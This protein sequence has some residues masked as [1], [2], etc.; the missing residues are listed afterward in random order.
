VNDTETQ[1]HLGARYDMGERN[2]VA[3]MIEAAAAHI[4]A[5]VHW[6]DPKKSTLRWHATLTLDG[7]EVCVEACKN[8]A[9]IESEDRSRYWD[10][11]NSGKLAT[12]V[13]RRMHAAKARD[14]K[15]KREW[16]EQR[17]RDELW[18]KLRGETK[19]ELVKLFGQD[20]YDACFDVDVLHLS[21]G[22]SVRIK[23]FAG[24][25]RSQNMSL[26]EAIRF[27]AVL[28]TSGYN[29]VKMATEDAS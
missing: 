18:D 1:T 20:V 27:V 10:Y 4:G 19:E 17:E 16:Q 12:A 8:G 6:H 28:Q 21:T 22:P 29:I 9:R 13:R 26:V 3:D 25:I 24:K 7:E 5:E 15:Q 11:H 2:S 14:A 23:V